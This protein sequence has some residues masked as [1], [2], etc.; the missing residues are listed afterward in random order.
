[1]ASAVGKNLCWFGG[2]AEEAAAQKGAA[3]K[4]KSA[5]PSEFARKLAVFLPH[6]PLVD[7]LGGI[8]LVEVR[9]EMPGAGGCPV[10]QKVLLAFG[11]D[12]FDVLADGWGEEVG[13]R[14]ADGAPVVPWLRTMRCPPACR[15]FQRF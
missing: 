9:H 12:Y 7:V 13:E 8:L 15:G 10:V 5:A 4:F 6:P 3:D 1:M 14:S 11:V 2:V